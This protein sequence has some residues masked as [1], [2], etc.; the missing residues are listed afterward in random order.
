LNR[1]TTFVLVPYSDSVYETAKTHFD[2]LLLK[3][4]TRAE[5]PVKWKQQGEERRI[6]GLTCTPRWVATAGEE[7]GKR[8]QGRTEAAQ[9]KRKG[10]E[11]AGHGGCL[12]RR[13]L[14]IQ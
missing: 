10:R 1:S 7:R 3:T 12:Y 9:G 2:L 11:G 13:K 14:N 8:H 5:T 6:H 4:A